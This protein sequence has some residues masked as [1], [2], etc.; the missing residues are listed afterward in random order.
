MSYIGWGV[1][2]LKSHNAKERALSI[3]D[4]IPEEMSFVLPPTTFPKTRE[5]KIARTRETG[6]I[7]N[8]LAQDAKRSPQ[9][10]NSNDKINDPKK[11]VAIGVL[12]GFIHPKEAQKILQEVSILE[13]SMDETGNW[14][15]P[16]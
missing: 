13:I 14:D 3:T 6:N 12:N 9:F 15:A 4:S 1:E 16:N 2:I 10:R 5:E 7:L 11:I 8:L